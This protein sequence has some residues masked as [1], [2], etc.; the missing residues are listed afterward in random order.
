[1]PGV[2]VFPTLSSEARKTM[3]TDEASQQANRAGMDP[4]RLVIIFYLLGGIILAL[5]LGH[6]LGSVFAGAGWS[7][8]ELIED[9]HLSSVLGVVLSAGLA[10]FCF[11]RFRGLSMEVASELM[12]VTWPSWEET[13]LS[14]IAVVVASLVA[15][16]IL[17]GIDTLS[18]KLM[19]DW[20]PALWGKL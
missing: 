8:A 16:I 5:F 7:D 17:F 3:A 12:K 9:W 19:V 10:V 20:L 11:I 13:R 2:P 18:Y 6:L 15:S 14:T 1:L 4:L